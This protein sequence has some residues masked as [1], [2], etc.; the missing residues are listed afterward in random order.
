LEWKL[1]GH[2]KQKPDLFL[3]GIG[4]NLDPEINIPKAL[5][6][7][8]AQVSILQVASIWQTSAVGSK[9]PDYLNSAVLI[10]SQLTQEQLK[11][12]ILTKIEKELGRVRSTDKYADRTIDLDIL[13]VDGTCLDEDLWSWAHVAVPAAEIY[14]DCINLQSGETLLQVS[15]RLSSGEN[16][17]KRIDLSNSSY[18][19]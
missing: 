19:R 2:N 10:E 4:S 1:S 18:K 15:R 6:L 7:L 3:I 11:S 5:Q 16:T 9:G 12:L 13:M 14:P 8:S 17:I